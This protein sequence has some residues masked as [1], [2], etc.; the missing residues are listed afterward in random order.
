MSP[1]KCLRTD[2]PFQQSASRER[3]AA[4]AKTEASSSGYRVVPP[5]ESR[6]PAPE[7]VVVKRSRSPQVYVTLLYTPLCIEVHC[8][9]ST[10]NRHICS[11]LYIKNPLHE[12]IYV[13]TRRF[14]F[15][16][17]QVREP[18]LPGPKAPPPTFQQ[19]LMLRQQL[20]EEVRRD[21]APHRAVVVL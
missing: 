15:T 6:K 14:K 11:P 9:R 1:G 20:E 2:W 5:Q 12:F 8:I 16:S 3:L 21:Q 13:Y 19:Q 10:L 17:F 18:P 4:Q 7:P